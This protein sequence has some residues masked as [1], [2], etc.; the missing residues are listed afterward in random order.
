MAALDDAKAEDT[1]LID[2]H[3]K[4]SIADA[5]VIATGRSTTHVASVADRVIRAVKESGRAAPSIEG[6]A[7]ATGC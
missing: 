3:G 2:L 5:M 4:T 1:T 6:L 7:P